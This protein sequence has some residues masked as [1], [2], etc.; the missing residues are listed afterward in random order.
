MGAAR[1]SLAIPMALAARAD[2]AARLMARVYGPPPPPDAVAAW[3]PAPLPPR[4][5]HTGA[6][7]HGGRYLW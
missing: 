4:S 2:A 1:S 6:A 7:G 5:A 3:A